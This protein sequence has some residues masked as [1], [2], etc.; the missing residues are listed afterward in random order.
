MNMQRI[1]KK[2]KIRWL[3]LFFDETGTIL[4]NEVDS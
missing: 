2:P 4:Q 3:P 1:V